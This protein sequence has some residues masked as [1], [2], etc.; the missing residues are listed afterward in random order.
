MLPFTYTA[1]EERRETSRDTNGMSCPTEIGACVGKNRGSYKK[2]SSVNEAFPYFWSPELTS[3]RETLQL[4]RQTH[5]GSEGMGL[6]MAKGILLTRKSS[7][8]LIN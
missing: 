6:I 3:Q 5:G 8:S 2:R 1:I 7:G 4:R